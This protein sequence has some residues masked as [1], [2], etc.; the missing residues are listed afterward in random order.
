[1]T[2]V[3]EEKANPGAQGGSVSLKVWRQLAWWIQV[4]WRRETV[5]DDFPGFDIAV[6]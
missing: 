3:A 5:S 6:I 2:E 1:M 4:D